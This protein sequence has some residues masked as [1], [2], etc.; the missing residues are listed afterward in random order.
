MTETFSEI[1]GRVTAHWDGIF[2]SP[3][4]LMEAITEWY[5]IPY[6]RRLDELPRRA[7][8]QGLVQ[9][10]TDFEECLANARAYAGP[11]LRQLGAALDHAEAQPL[12]NALSPRH[13][14]IVVDVG[15]AAGILG[16]FTDRA[17]FAHYVGIDT[18]RWMRTLARAVFET[19]L[20]DITLQESLASNPDHGTYGSFVSRKQYTFAFDGHGRPRIGT[21][22][23]DRPTFAVHEGIDD[24]VGWLRYVENVASAVDL[25]AGGAR[26]ITV[27]AV[28]NHLLFQMTDV[29]QTV[30][31][32]LDK[33]RRASAL[34]G[35]RAF[36]VSIE[37]GTLYKPDRL[38]TQGFDSIVAGMP[39]NVTRLSVPGV[40][41]YLT[42]NSRGDA[43]V[44]ILRF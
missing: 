9:P 8:N 1:A 2:R 13:E 42:G 25:A 22:T 44:R 6:P 29:P 40:G 18:N 30:R 26:P 12:R 35:V 14:V 17:G 3:N 32:V 15:C 28:M 10:D 39:V 31:S 43:A 7:S 38:G 41:S 11:H 37:P 5:G 16:L 24:H 33:C 36:M 23:D 4:P 19:T 34:P 20:N 21:I 27:L